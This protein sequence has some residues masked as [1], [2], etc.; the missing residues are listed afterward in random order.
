MEVNP[1]QILF[2]CI[3]H[4]PFGLVESAVEVF[5][6]AGI[7]SGVEAADDDAVVVISVVPFISIRCLT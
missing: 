3:W 5:V 7:Y 2:L 4:L 6:E 1:H